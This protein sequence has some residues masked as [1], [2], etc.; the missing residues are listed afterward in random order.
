MAE[1]KSAIGNGNISINE[2][3]RL[4]REALA[5]QQ[6]LREMK[7]NLEEQAG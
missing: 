4:L 5:I 1:Y 2:S 7:G 6:V 3:K